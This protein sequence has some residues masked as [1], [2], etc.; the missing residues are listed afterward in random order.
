M[1][2]YYI[3]ILKLENESY[4]LGKTPN[5]NF[6]LEN[7]HIL[8]KRLPDFIV[9]NK[10][11]KIIEFI[12]DCT[13]QEVDKYTLKYM[14]KYGIRNVRGGTYDSHYLSEENRNRIKHLI[15]TKNL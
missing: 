2:R 4:F 13:E 5:P 6:K 7:L 8:Y 10:P 3:F 14:K 1:N 12:P 11:I 15:A 9:I